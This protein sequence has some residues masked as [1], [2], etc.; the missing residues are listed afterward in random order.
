MDP[1]EEAPLTAANDQRPPHDL[2]EAGEGVVD[3]VGERP[4]HHRGRDPVVDQRDGEKAIDYPV[5]V[6]DPLHAYT[7]QQPETVSLPVIS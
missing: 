1:P 5:R 3:V 4:R 2:I 6:A 7:R